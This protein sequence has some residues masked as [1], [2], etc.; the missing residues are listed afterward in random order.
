ML[1]KNKLRLSAVAAI[2]TAGVA[3]SALPAMAD[4]TAGTFANLSGVG[5][6]TIQDVLSGLATK[7]PAIGSY[8]ATG[9][10]T[11][12]TKADG[13]TFTRPVGSGAGVE[14]L[15]ASI[16]STGSKMYKST[17]ITGQVDFARSSSGPSTA[18]SGTQLTFIPFA[19][20]AV[21]FAVN[22][23]SD[24]PRDIPVGTTAQDATG[25]FTLRNIFRCVATNYTDADSN[26]VTIRPLLP[27]TGSGT[28]KFWLATLGL[29]EATKGSCVTDVSNSV[30]EHDGTFITGAGDIAPFSIAQ[31]IAQGNHALLPTTVVERRGQA[32]LG[33]IAGV[34]PVVGTTGGG[35]EM[36]P[37]FSVYRNVYNVV[38]TA[39]LL[40]D[41]TLS[42]TFSGTTSS[43]C[44]NITT[45]KQ[46]GFAPI[47]SLCGNTTTFKQGYSL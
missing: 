41:T 35:V 21:S 42:G 3:F 10:A 24:F 25:A 43:V 19:K 40:T 2:V 28:R 7:I 13:P 30:I 34:K 31:Y 45:I 33:A 20:D 23:A 14:A 38:E 6:D 29:T 12:Q 32:E 16:N 46:Y 44:A 47:G 8:D 18:F 5:S 39:R 17:S 26:T 37:A 9:S 11:V 36:N 22:A 1:N 15:S 4:P 27:Q